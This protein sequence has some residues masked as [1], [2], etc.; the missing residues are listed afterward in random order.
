MNP[1]PSVF[2]LALPATQHLESDLPPDEPSTEAVLLEAERLG[3]FSAVFSS[4]K[5]AGAE[6][7]GDAWR[8]RI[9]ANT[10][11]NLFLKAEQAHFVRGLRE[12]GIPCVPVRGVLLTERFYPD[13]SWRAIA[14]ID[15]LIHASDVT[16]AHRVSKSLG[17]TDAGN[18]W[19]NKALDRLARRAAFHHSEL[20]FVSTKGASIELHWDW[21]EP[22]LPKGDLCCVPEAYL[23]YLC[24]HAGKHF[25]C[26]LRWLT[27]IELLLREFH[28]TLNW[29]LF[30]RLARANDAS[31]SCA[32]TFQLCSTLFGRELEPE[33]RRSSQP[34][35]KRLARDAEQWLIEGNRS[36]FWDHPAAQL[37]RVDGPR[38]RLR[39]IASWLAPAP[40]HWTRPDGC[41][42]S[43]AEVWF[44]RYRRFIFLGA[45]ALCPSRG[46]RRCFRKASELSTA[47]WTM[48][49]RAWLLLPLMGIASRLV[50][51]PRLHAWAGRLRKD[52]TPS[53]PAEAARRAAE[54]VT[55]A[56]R[57]HLLPLLCLPRS[58]TLLRLLSRQ[59]VAAELRM[60]VRRENGTILGHAWVEYQGLPINDPDHPEKRFRG[61]VSVRN[62][63][64]L[65]AVAAARPPAVSHK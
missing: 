59:G 25:W 28:T 47:E 33:L 10:A 18:P 2:R 56:A 43:T 60:G 40:R 58:F 11:H 36:P 63:A 62:Q 5:Q 52:V 4:L 48:L 3:V 8:R 15:L 49:L 29:D 65:D 30:W 27:D 32:S 55:V 1:I 7:R 24:R 35:G 37:L 50:R 6:P 31:R 26:D 53:Q 23:V 21:V 51:F 42:P 46:W 20:R 16:A 64:D 39:R 57:Y 34:A 22:A 45:A 38:N 9:Q 41:T 17:M 61:F 12:N 19:N 14:D 54:L 44:V 13:L